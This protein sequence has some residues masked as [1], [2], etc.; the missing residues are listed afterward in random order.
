MLCALCRKIPYVG[1]IIEA[2]FE[3]FLEEQRQKYL[4]PRGDSHQIVSCFN[5]LTR[6]HRA[7]LCVSPCIATCSLPILV[8]FHLGPQPHSMLQWVLEKLVMLMVAY[9]I[10]SIINSMAQAYAKRLD[11]E[12]NK[13]QAEC[14]T[15]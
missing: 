8:S 9:F 14:K 15:D 4:S 11:E 6:M 3:E 1:P 5:S 7:C 2:P 13:Q 10:L 12:K